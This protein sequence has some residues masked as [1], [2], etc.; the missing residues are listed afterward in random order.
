[1]CKYFKTD[2]IIIGGVGGSGTRIIAEIIKKTGYF[3]GDELNVANDN[4]TIAKEFPNFRDSI[5]KKG[6]LFIRTKRKFWNLRKKGSIFTDKIIY[7][8]LDHFEQ[9]MSEYYNSQKESFIGWGWKIPGSFFILE[10][11]AKQFPKMKYI[12]TIRNGLDM[13][14]SSNQNQLNNWGKYYGVDPAT[15][16]LQKASLEYWYNANTKAI[17]QAEELFKDRFLL[18]YFE[19]LCLNPKKE[20]KK[21]IQFLKIDNVE[22][23]NLVKLVK[24]QPTTGRYKNNDLSIFDESDLNKVREFDYKI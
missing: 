16:P 7:R 22:I 5:Q 24:I 2:P 8:S 6:S 11:L 19:E 10:H 4:L 3:I 18:I 23:S 20:I 13:S 1:M 14:F 12:H 9:R 15:K 17:S 21:I